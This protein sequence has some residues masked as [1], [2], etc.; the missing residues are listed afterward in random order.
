VKLEKDNEFGNIVHADRLFQQFLVDYNTMIEAQRLSFIRLN[1]K[2]IHYE[3]L[4]GLQEAINRGETDPSC[5]GR[6]VVLPSSFTGGM[7]YMFNNCQ[8]SMTICKR[9]S[10]PDLFIT[11][12]CNVNWHEICDALGPKGLSLL[13]RLDIVC[14]VFKIKLDQMITYFEKNNFFWS[15]NCR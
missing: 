1:K 8:D 10:Y 5:L 6:R 15:N 14:R 3:I 9:F 12:T 2:L 4:N 11:M 13:D 7:R